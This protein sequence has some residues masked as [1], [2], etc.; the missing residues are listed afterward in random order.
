[1]HSQEPAICPNPEP[2][3]SSPR[4]FQ[5]TFESFIRKL[6]SLLRLHS[7]NGSFPQISQPNPAFTSPRSNR[8]IELQTYNLVMRRGTA[9]VRSHCSAYATVLWRYSV[10]S[11]EGERG[12]CSTHTTMDNASKNSPRGKLVGCLHDRT[13]STSI[14]NCRSTLKS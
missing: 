6:S 14:R 1:M 9:V 3:Q 11:G 8:R 13:L 5:P 12:E 2:D 7:P 10:M 4:L